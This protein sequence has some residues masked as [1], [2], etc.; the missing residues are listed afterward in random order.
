MDVGI[1]SEVG[2]LSFCRGIMNIPS[3]TLVLWSF[4]IVICC[5]GACLLAPT[6]K[7][8]HQFKPLGASFM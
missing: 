4:F 5:L 8:K 3:L 2:F 6:R 7:I 1:G